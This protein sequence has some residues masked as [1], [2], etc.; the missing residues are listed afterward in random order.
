M[1]LPFV[2]ARPAPRGRVASP[3]RV[4]PEAL[5]RI[6]E[7]EIKARILA[8][9]GFLGSYRSVFRGSGLEFEEVREY[10]PGDEIRTIDWNVSAR[11]GLTFVKKYREERELNVLLA[12]D[13]SSSSWFGSGGASKRELAANVGG[14]LA[15]AAL[16]AND[17]VGLVLFADGIREYIQPRRGHDHLLRLIRAVLYAEPQRARTRIADAAAFIGRVSKKRS[18][19]FILSDFLDEGFDTP[20]RTLGR[21]H[22]VIALSLN[23]PRELELPRVGVITLEDAETGEVRTV[24]TDRADVRTAFADAAQSRRLERLRAFGRMSLDQVE[25]STDRPY[26]PALVSFFNARTRKH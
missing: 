3:K 5:R 7:L 15:V 6:R 11:M 21:K 1:R 16:H 4:A 14:L 19:I 23:D 17:R 9:E 18:V 26:V 8:D 25:L 10:Q 13:V 22:D 12:V 20:L 2:S 24:D